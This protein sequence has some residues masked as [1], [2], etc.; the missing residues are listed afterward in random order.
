MTEKSAAALF[1][2]DRKGHSPVSKGRE[3]L[4]VPSSDEARR[5]GSKGGKAS[6]E[7]RRR[8]ANFRKTLNAILTAKIDRPEWEP[9]LKELGLECTL[10]SA[11]NMAMVKEGLSGNV[12]AYVAVRDTIGQS[13]KSE[14]EIERQRI[15][16]EKQ[17]MEIERLNR[18]LGNDKEERDSDGFIEALKSDAKSTFEEAGDLIET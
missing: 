6:G 8:K 15:E 12:K 7:A 11:L 2:F 3:N 13:T 1:L 17:K 10:E 14:E 9:L 18:L 5:N 4:I 16:I